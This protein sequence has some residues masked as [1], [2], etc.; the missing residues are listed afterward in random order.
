MSQSSIDKA[1]V[2][3]VVRGLQPF[4]IVEKEPFRE[5]IKAFQ[6]HAKIISRPTLCSRIEDAAKKVKKGV[7]EAMRAVDHIATTTDCW[8]VRRSF[9]GVTAHWVDPDSLTRRSAALACRQLGGSHTFDVLAGA[10]NDIH[11]E[12]GIRDKIVRTTTDNGSNFLKAFRVFGEDRNDNEVSDVEEPGEEMEEEEGEEEV[13]FVNVSVILAEDDGMEFELPKHQ[14]CACH[15][16]NLVS[17]V[18]AEK[19]TGNDGYK[20]MYRSTFSKCQALWNKCGR[21]TQAAEA[22]ED[23]FSLQLLRPNATRWNS[24]FMAVERL[25]RIVR[26]KGEPALRSVCTDLKVPM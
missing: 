6:P 10:L 25:L 4:S 26:D 13:E 5:L 24:M 1:I 16:L 18:D 14:R 11:S 12:Y 23:S 8:S 21:S 2:R 19:A 22:V 3:Y 7:T 15:L 9:I 20:K 17:T